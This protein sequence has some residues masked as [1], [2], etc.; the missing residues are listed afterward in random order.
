M[1]NSKK[2]ELSL[3]AQAIAELVSA[4]VMILLFIGKMYENIFH[5]RALHNIINYTSPLIFV[6]IAAICVVSAKYN[7]QP[8]DELSRELTLKATEIAVKIELCVAVFCGIIMHLQGNRRHFEYYRIMGSDVCIF[9]VFLC[10][11]YLAAKNIAFLWFDRTP[12]AEEE[13]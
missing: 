13:E 5:N 2:K 9:G 8:N 6:I 10:G 12:K 3:K 11:V 1:K 4:A 7:K